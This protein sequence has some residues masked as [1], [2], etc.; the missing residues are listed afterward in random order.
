ME[1]SDD[2]AENMYSQVH[3]GM[4]QLRGWRNYR[5]ATM[6][7]GDPDRL[8]RGRV[9]DLIETEDSWHRMAQLF[10]GPARSGCEEPL[11]MPGLG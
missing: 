3:R 2:P 8:I 11:G 9:G 5:D 6:N 10:R 1:T 4:T 7:E